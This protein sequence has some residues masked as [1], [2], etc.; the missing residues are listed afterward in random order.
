MLHAFLRS[1]EKDEKTTPVMQATIS[2]TGCFDG[3]VSR[4]KMGRFGCVCKLWRAQRGERVRCALKFSVIKHKGN[5]LEVLVKEAL[6][7]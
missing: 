3:I 1:L 5:D 4:G 7:G 6:V 2:E